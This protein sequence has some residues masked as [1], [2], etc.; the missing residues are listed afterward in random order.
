VFSCSPLT[1][2]SLIPAVDSLTTRSRAPEF[3]C[4]SQTD[5]RCWPL[6]D[7]CVA[8]YLYPYKVV[9]RLSI[10]QATGVTAE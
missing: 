9:V 7:H 3:A 1:I 2:Q 5:G 6:V 10:G 4:L 8:C